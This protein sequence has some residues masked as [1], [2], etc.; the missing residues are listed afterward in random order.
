[1]KRENAGWCT[2]TGQ[3]PSAAP[4]DESHTLET[5]EMVEIEM[6]QTGEN[7]S[8]REKCNQLGRVIDIVREKIWRRSILQT[9]LLFQCSGSHMGEN[10]NSDTTG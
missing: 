4:A 6:K 10:F 7:D 5:S 9:N 8:E 3:S 2:S 1:M